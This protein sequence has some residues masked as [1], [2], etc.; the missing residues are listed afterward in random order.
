M[1]SLERL[2]SIDPSL[3]SIPDEELEHVRVK[4]YELGQFAFELWLK[5]RNE[6]LM[7]PNR[8]LGSVYSLSG[9]ISGFCV[10]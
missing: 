10:T 7:V 5:E 9:S 1:I 8:P 3:Q 6:K 4:L 2:K